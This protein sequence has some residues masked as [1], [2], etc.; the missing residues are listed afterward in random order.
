MGFQS[1][2]ANVT[3]SN[4]TALGYQCLTLNTAFFNT[5][6]GQ[7]SLFRNTTG[8]QNVAVGPSSLSTNVIG[9]G[10]TAMGYFSLVNNTGSDNTAIGILSL[11]ANTTGNSNVA[12]GGNTLITNTTGTANTALGY[13]ADV[14]SAALTNATAIGNSASVNA[15]NKVRL[16]NTNVTVIEGQVAYTSVSDGRFKTEIVENVPGLDFIMKLRPV[17][18]HFDTRKFDK[19]LGRADSLVQKQASA[20]AV[21]SGILH[22][23]FIAQDV[24]KAAQQSGFDF[25]GLHKPQTDQDNYGLAYAEFTV[26]LV[27]AV[28]EQ[29]KTIEEQQKM[30]AELQKQVAELMKRRD[31]QK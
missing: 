12:Y 4:N 3:G 25:D 22:T 8:T 9:S 15:S 31:A 10:N 13:S 28:Q 17:T 5:A 1:L 21:S 27:K 14:A 6:V 30:I 16:G 29:Q 26:P 20:Y 23:G 19:F 18:Y 2:N 7:G 11:D 24:E